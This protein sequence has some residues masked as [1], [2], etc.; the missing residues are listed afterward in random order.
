MLFRSTTFSTLFA[1]AS[2][3]IWVIA[4]AIPQMVPLFSESF[5]NGK[6]KL[7]EFYVKQ[8]F[9]FIYLTF[10]IFISIF[11]L[12]L[13]ILENI[14]LEWGL[15]NYLLIIPLIIPLLC[16]NLITFS[17]ALGDQIIIG[18]DN[19]NFLM[20]VRIVEDTIKIL[21]TFSFLVWLQIPQDRKSVV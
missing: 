2:T 8:S 16:K 10:G 17:N 11:L 7:A 4:T 15:V 18:T 13:T 5:L 3:F 6:K 19:P 1:F 20:K 14:L 9:R 21:F 12:I